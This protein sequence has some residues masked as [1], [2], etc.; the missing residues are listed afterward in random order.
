[1][2]RAGRHNVI[3]R[4]V[5]VRMMRTSRGFCAVEWRSRSCAE[6]LEN[7]RCVFPTS[8]DAWRWLELLE[9]YQVT[10]CSDV[11]RLAGAHGSHGAWEWAEAKCARGRDALVREA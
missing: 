10:I 2:L 9:R 6:R 11:A 3:P 8:A 5:E 7:G 1:L 4:D